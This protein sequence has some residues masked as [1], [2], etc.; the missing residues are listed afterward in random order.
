MVL[1]TCYIKGTTGQTDALF[2]SGHC[3]VAFQKS[4]C[5]AQSSSRRCATVT[6]HSTFGPSQGSIFDGIA[7]GASSI[8]VRATEYGLARI[9]SG[10]E[11]PRIRNCN[12]GIN[13]A[14]TSTITGSGN[15]EFSNNTTDINPTGTSDPSHIP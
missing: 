2:I 6:Q 4:K 12:I 11:H 3:N 10:S 15:V 7:P 1:L 9:G 5:D 13:A 14:T 8:G